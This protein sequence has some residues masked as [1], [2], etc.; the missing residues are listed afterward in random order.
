VQHI[1]LTKLEINQN[2]V[3]ALSF[4]GGL[5][6][7]LNNYSKATE[8]LDKALAIS[9]NNVWALKNKGGLLLALANEYEARQN[10]DKVLA[11]KN[12]AE[13][14]FNKSLSLNPNNVI[15]LHGIAYALI[16]YSD[17]Y[18]KALEYVNKALEI[19]PDYIQSVETKALVLD[20]LDRNREAVEW[21]NKVL[22][23]PSEYIIVLLNNKGIALADLR[24]YEQALDWYDKALE[25]GTG[26]LD[27]IANKARILIEL[28]KYSDALKLIDQ[29]LKKNPVHKGLLCNK[30]EILEKMGYKD[31]AIPIK[32]KLQKLYS[33]NYKCG[34]K[35]TRLGDIAGVPFV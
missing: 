9:P 23:K 4:K 25:K 14:N 15:I 24:H 17:D 6:V 16:L 13:K 19:N 30:A 21:Y 32:E 28:D 33:E 10:F 20:K 35:K 22:N 27:T 12:E 7:A 18:N 8:Y 26:D 29:N 34:F 2:D 5:L 11:L 1:T 3:D 31:M